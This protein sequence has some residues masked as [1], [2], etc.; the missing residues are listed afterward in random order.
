MS[1]MGDGSAHAWDSM[2]EFKE[3]S[4]K[5]DAQFTTDA[6]DITENTLCV[7]MTVGANTT[8]FKHHHPAQEVVDIYEYYDPDPTMDLDCDGMNADAPVIGY[9]DADGGVADDKRN[10]PYIVL[11]CGSAAPGVVGLWDINGGFAKEEKYQE[12]Y[13]ID[14]GYAYHPDDERHDWFGDIGFTNSLDGG[15]ASDRDFLNKSMKVRIRDNQIKSALRIV[16]DTKNQLVLRDDGLFMEDNFAKQS[17]FDSYSADLKQAFDKFATTY[18]GYMENIEVASNEAALLA[19]IDKI[20]TNTLANMKKVVNAVENDTF[21]NECKAYIQNE[22]NNNLHVGIGDIDIY[23]WGNF[24][25]REE[26]V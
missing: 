9:I 17:D 11:D 19:R 12:Y 10:Y 14:G 22:I 7:D 24:D 20:I 6:I 4:W 3:T 8:D 1:Y 26:K 23:R 16:N 2:N 21:E 13:N 15:F 25:K 18:R 5:E